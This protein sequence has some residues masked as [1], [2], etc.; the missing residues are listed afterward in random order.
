V[1]W[2][3]VGKYT[4]LTLFLAVTMEAFESKYDAQA[5]GELKVRIEPFPNP[6]TL[7]YRSW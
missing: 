7:F 6:G 2:V 3:I 5:S 4:F 1:V